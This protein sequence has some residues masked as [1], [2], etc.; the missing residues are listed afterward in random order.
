MDEQTIYLKVECRIFFPLV[1]YLLPMAGKYKQSEIFYGKKM[2]STNSLFIWR[3]RLVKGSFRIEALT[4]FQIITKNRLR[5]CSISHRVHYINCSKF[6]QLYSMTNH[7]YVCCRA[8]TVFQ[9]CVQL[10][11]SVRRATRPSR[12]PSSATCSSRK[13]AQKCW[14]S[15]TL[16]FRLEGEIIQNKTS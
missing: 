3:T 7:F 12:P 6:I 8:T 4:L 11:V 2:S 15:S 1:I 16:L 10:W 9:R 14:P 13:H 5:S